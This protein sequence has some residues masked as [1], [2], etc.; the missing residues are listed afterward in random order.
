[1]HKKSSMWAYVMK[2]GIALMVLIAV[3]AILS[4]QLEPPPEGE[5]LEKQLWEDFKAKNWNSIEAKISPDFQSIH[6]DGARNDKEELRLI[7]NL[8]L[9]KYTL[10]DFKITERGSTIIITYMV[11]A[12]ETIDQ[13]RM[14]KNPMPRMSVWQKNGE[15]WE[16]IAHANLDPIKK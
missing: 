9:G 6:S 10:S 11:A 15:K 2:G 4:A 13:K 5:K 14:P 12:E 3:V 16:W 8:N 7:K 1:M